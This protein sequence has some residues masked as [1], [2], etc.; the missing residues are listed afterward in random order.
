M[1]KNYSVFLKV[2][3]LFLVLFIV[4]GSVAVA[5]DDLD[6]NEMRKKAQQAQANP[7]QLKYQIVDVQ[8]KDG[9]FTI[10]YDLNDSNEYEY[11]VSLLLF[12]ESNPQ[13]SVKPKTL[14]GDIGQGKFSGTGR[15]IIW[16]SRQDLKRAL[17]GNDFYFV[18]YIQK[19]EPSHFPWTWVG[20]GGVAAGAAAILLLSHK[21]S[22]E[23]G[24]TELPAINVSRPQ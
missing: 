20:I 8:E 1:S 15:Q 16:D 7:Q 22:S 21:S 3:P 10:R 17:V 4:L 18:L 23:P 9:L 24:S 2:H 12:R 14:R 19:I 5:Q 6:V 13:F 11:T